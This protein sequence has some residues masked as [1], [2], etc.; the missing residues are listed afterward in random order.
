MSRP[1]DADGPDG[2]S[3]A[4]TAPDRDDAD[5]AG[6]AWPMLAAAACG[7]DEVPRASG[8]AS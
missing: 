4:T 6:R 7:D 1:V 8:R 3:S 5:T 2:D